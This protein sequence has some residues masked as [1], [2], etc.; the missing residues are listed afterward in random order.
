MRNEM[1]VLACAGL[2]AGGSGGMHLFLQSANSS[3]LTSAA[4]QSFESG[5]YETSLANF[6]TLKKETDSP[7][8]TVLVKIEESKD[9]LV[10]KEIFEIAKKAADQV[11]SLEK[12]IAQELSALKQEALAEKKG[13]EE[14]L[15][16]VSVTKKELEST[17]LQ[18]EQTEADLQAQKVETTKA[19]EEAEKEKIKK[20]GAELGVYVGMLA[21]GRE[22]LDNAIAE[23]DAEKDATPPILISQGKV[24]FTEVKEKG[25]NLLTS[26][27]PETHKEQTQ[28]LLQAVALFIESSRDLGSAVLYMDNKEDH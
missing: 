4:F 19:K 17:L 7:G 20:F 16:E 10:A 15:H 28:K 23:I 11:R 6:N 25:E 13:R 24:L 9:L 21:Q 12:K 27:T 18:K 1:I 8:Q 22:Y 3:D 26:R 14:V 2:L 5:D